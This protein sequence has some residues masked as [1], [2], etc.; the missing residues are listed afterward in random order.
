MTL[1]LEESADSLARIASLQNAAA[2]QKVK[3]KD[4]KQTGK[5]KASDSK[6]Q[7]G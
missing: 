5:D 1:G 3:G 4:A 2:G 7:A 6:P